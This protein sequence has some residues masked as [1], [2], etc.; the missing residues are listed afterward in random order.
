M[1]TR[2]PTD[3][4]ALTG[5][6]VTRHRD[7]RM[8]TRALGATASRL[9]SRRLAAA[10]G[11]ASAT[12]LSLALSSERLADPSKPSRCES[13]LLQQAVSSKPL[14][15][16]WGRLAPASGHADAAPVLMRTLNRSTSATFSPRAACALSI[17]HTAKRTLLLWTTKDAFGLGERRPGRSLE[18]CPAAAIGLQRW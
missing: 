2:G 16:A 9:A 13:S 4:T 5:G 11:A 3:V 7:R 6:H 18:S 15:F 12:A 17:S 8:W 10:A 14:L 1:R